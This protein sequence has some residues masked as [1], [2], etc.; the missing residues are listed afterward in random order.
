MRHSVPFGLFDRERRLRFDVNALCDI[1]DALGE[2]VGTAFTDGKAGIKTLRTLLWA[3]LKWEDRTLTPQKVGDLL[4]AYL[5]NGGT[6]DVVGDTVGR[7]LATSG[8]I[9]KEKDDTEE[10]G[11]PTGN[12]P[13]GAAS[14]S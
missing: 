11:T 4:N 1:E 10:K 3:G 7:A 8:L 9:G 5:E 6:I 2:S 13:P 12:P 14:P